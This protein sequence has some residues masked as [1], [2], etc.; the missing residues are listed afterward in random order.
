MRTYS[1]DVWSLDLATLRWRRHVEET[2]ASCIVDEEG[3]ASDMRWCAPFGGSGRAFHTA[4]CF[5]TPAPMGAEDPVR[6][7][8]P[9]TD[10]GVS[11]LVFIF[12]GRT[13]GGALTS[14]LHMIDTKDM[15]WM[16]LSELVRGTRVPLLSS[17][18]RRP[19]GARNNMDDGDRHGGTDWLF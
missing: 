12:G 11:D 14:S 8:G 17:V 9:V 13:S 6:G 16:S 2:S 10:D 5:E 3:D 7:R 1:D 19:H 18:P 4:V 15:R